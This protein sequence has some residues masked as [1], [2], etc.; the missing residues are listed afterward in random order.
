MISFRI[1]A[2]CLEYDV[3]LLTSD[4]RDL[5]PLVRHAGLRLG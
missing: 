5:A 1:A 3:P 4:R 2:V